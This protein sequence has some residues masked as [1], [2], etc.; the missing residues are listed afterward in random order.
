MIT[1]TTA[2]FHPFPAL[3][4]DFRARTWELT[5]ESRIVEVRVVY[6]QPNAVGVGVPE[7]GMQTVDWTAHRLPLMRHLRSSTAAPA[8]LQ[9]CQGLF[10]ITTTPYDGFDP[11]PKDDLQQERYVWLNFD[12]DM[13]AIGDTDLSN[14]RAVAH[15]VCRLRLERALSNE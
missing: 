6:H 12:N 5:V 8:Q 7:L 9:T 3:P 13:V 11:V 15:Q 14:F 10:E 1:T 2:T 4:F